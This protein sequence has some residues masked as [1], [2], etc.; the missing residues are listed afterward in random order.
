[1]L[2]ER[3]KGRQAGNGKSA[4]VVERQ[5]F[6]LANSG[7]VKKKYSNFGCLGKK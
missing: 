7:V 5:R 1:V 4:M 6:V 3:Y 2:P